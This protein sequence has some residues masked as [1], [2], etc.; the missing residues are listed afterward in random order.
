MSNFIINSNSKIKTSY[1]ILYMSKILSENYISINNK[2]TNKDI[3]DYL[4]PLYNITKALH[5]K[6]FRDVQ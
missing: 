6:D 1:R 3:L 4:T 2:D 5:Y